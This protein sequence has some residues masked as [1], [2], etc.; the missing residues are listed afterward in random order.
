MKALPEKGDRAWMTRTQ[1]EELHQLSIFNSDD[2][3]FG[4]QDELAA[5]HTKLQQLML[6]LMMSTQS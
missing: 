3:I 5:L 1:V 6:S 2:V 4:L